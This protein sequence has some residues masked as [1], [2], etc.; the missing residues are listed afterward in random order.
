[1]GVGDQHHDQADLPSGETVAIVQEAGWAP[2]G[3]SRLLRNISRPQLGFDPRTV[4]PV[5]VRNYGR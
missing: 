5:A 1:M 3:G 4:Q 2:R